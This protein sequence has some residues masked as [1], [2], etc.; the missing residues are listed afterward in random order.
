M[1]YYYNIF[2]ILIRFSK[3]YLWCIYINKIL[4]FHVFTISGFLSAKK[5][6]ERPVVFLDILFTTL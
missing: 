5:A 4:N 3:Y 1:P 2:K 6:W